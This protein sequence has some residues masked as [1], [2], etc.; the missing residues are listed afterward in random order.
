MKN[1]ILINGKIFICKS[2]E[3]IYDQP[4]ELCESK[5]SSRKFN[6]VMVETLDG[7]DAVFVCNKCFK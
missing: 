1:E 3:E 6:K 7:T 2:F 4:C 5:W